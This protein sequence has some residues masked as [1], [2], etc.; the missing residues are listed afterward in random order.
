MR[1]HR[2]SSFAPPGQSSSDE[3]AMHPSSM[4]PQARPSE[5]LPHSPKQQGSSPNSGSIQVEFPPHRLKMYQEV[6]RQLNTL[7]NTINALIGMFPSVGD[8]GHTTASILLEK[9]VL[10]EL[11]H[12]LTQ[13]AL[14]LE[15]TQFYQHLSN[16]HSVKPLLEQFSFSCNVRSA[17]P[18]IHVSAPE[19][20]KPEVPSPTAQDQPAVHIPKDL[21]GSNGKLLA[22][23]I[24]PFVRESVQ[25]MKSSGAG[26]NVEPC[27]PTLCTVQST[28]S[29]V[30]TNG[31]KDEVKRLLTIVLKLFSE[32]K[33]N[34]AQRTVLKRAVFSNN[35]QIY[36]LFGEF[37]RNGKI[38]PLLEHVE[39]ILRNPIGK[40]A[41][42]TNSVKAS[43]RNGVKA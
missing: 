42:V 38:E 27:A 40:P 4:Q 29:N 25:S 11:K 13:P 35:R 6:F 22:P 17:P 39:D 37:E 34:D 36:E 24:K 3:L 14:F 2:R 8:L 20:A 9:Q 19:E 21:P 5:S 16:S 32:K 10:V 31:C 33:I 1:Q 15:Q 12:E 28:R 41:S 43:P 18:T 26:N 7:K 23:A 30:D